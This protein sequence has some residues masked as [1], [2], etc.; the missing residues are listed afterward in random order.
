[1]PVVFLPERR[2]VLLAYLACRRDWVT[3][4]EL[5]ELF[6]PGRPQAAARSNLRKVLLLV[7][8]IGSLLRLEQQGDRLR[9]VPDSDV[10]RFDAACTERRYDDALHLYQPAL[11]QGLDAGLPN[12]ADDWLGFERQRVAARW[13]D[14]AARRLAELADRPSEAA[15]LADTLLRIDPFFDGALLALGQA[16]IAL[17]QHARGSRALQEHGQ[18]LAADFGIEPPAG[19]R[20]LAT[21][22]RESAARSSA[23]IVSTTQA[24]GF[25]GRRIELAQLQKLLL[26]PTC[27]VLTITGP[28]GVGKSS[29]ARATLAAVAEPHFG[30]AAW[31]VAL[32]DLSSVAQVPGRIAS[33]LALE[34]RGSADPWRQIESHLA[35]RRA[36][37]ALDNSEH[38][39]G[40]A[41]SLTNLLAACP[42]LK[43]LNT[44]RGRLSLV[45]EWLQPLE[46]LPLPDADETE[47]EVLLS[48]DAVRLFDTRARA[49]APA[50]DLGRQAAD[51]VRLL[52]AVEGLPL[53]IELSAA[54]VRLLPV[55]EI[56][57]ELAGSLDL[58]A[59]DERANERANE[60]THDRSLRASFA[61]SW[62]MLTPG[63]RE[64][65]A[66]LAQ[67][68]GGFG[69]QMAL[70]VARSPLPVLAALIDRSLLRT[71]GDGRFSLHP[72]IRQCALEMAA[73][74][75]LDIAALRTRHIAYMAQWLERYDDLRRLAT[76]EALIDFENELPHARAAWQ[77]SIERLE[78]D[79]VSR[80]ALALMFY[81]ET[82]GLWQEGMAMLEGAS[83]VFDVTQRPGAR[84]TA[85]ALRS[86]ALLQLRCGHLAEA[87][88]SA[89]QALKLT[90]RGGDRRVAKASLNV[91]GLSLWRRGQYTQALH[92][93]EQALKR[94]KEDG[95][96]LGAATYMGNAGLVEKSLGR[97]DEALAHCTE[98]AA[99]HRRIDNPRG[100][101]SQLNA[102][103]NV[104]HA[105][106][107][108]AAALPPLDEALRL[109]EKHDFESLRSMFVVNI[110]IVRYELG[111]H[112]SAQAW[113][114]RGLSEVRQHGERGVEATTLQSLA[115]LAIARRQGSVARERI[116][117]A[118][119][120]ANSLNSPAL[121]L[122][123]VSIHA[124]L[125]A[126][127][128]EPRRAAASWR[129][130]MLQPGLDSVDRNEAERELDALAAAGVD[131]ANADEPPADG[132]L[133]GV[134]AMVAQETLRKRPS[135]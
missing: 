93:F 42:E 20:E 14:V 114:D 100:V 33:L 24:H 81:F 27:R 104:H 16:C 134:L 116:G 105:R 68:P 125:L 43:V 59:E 83:T 95:D 78:P 56:V 113:L 34:L 111:D 53:A 102:I 57:S 65:L 120:I 54:W 15:T 39:E 40:L 9:W 71:D 101:V 37:L 51:V 11:L 128:G 5:A 99:V 31:W 88:A 6:W 49:A 38:L 46:G 61:H 121:Q 77:W 50:F 69:R 75:L 23:P 45:G 97:Y 4:D 82:R 8:N 106:R 1:M 117:E 130:L 10:Q 96:S 21:Q 135:S 18:R 70:Q 44:S 60:G 79:L 123:I 55:R 85:V 80:S 3:R 84:A 28:G 133:P 72:L 19:L 112:D 17:G 30:G 7:H 74:Q 2:F 32:D 66:Q 58:L 92:V 52:H 131:L 108:W 107:D 64:C 98:A 25:I 94:A 122:P 62:R 26:Q 63:E 29:L 132:T 119:A 35:Q 36:L 12:G 90:S 13:Q 103:A 47:P 118:L 22:L 86:L 76:R 87:E 41:E 126:A 129:W 73:E 110:G 115:R 89:R 67:L 127:E 91:L 124:K 109:C 48:N